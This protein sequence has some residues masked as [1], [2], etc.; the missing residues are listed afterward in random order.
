MQPGCKNRAYLKCVVKMFL[1]RKQLKHGEKIDDNINVDLRYG[2]KDLVQ[3]HVKWRSF[4]YFIVFDR[5]VMLK[6]ILMHV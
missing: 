3:N 1:E 5:R 2:L 6:I 4:R